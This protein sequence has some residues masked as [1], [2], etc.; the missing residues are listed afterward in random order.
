VKALFTVIGGLALGTIVSAA[1]LVPAFANAKYFPVSQ[2]DIPIDNG[3]N[4][5]LLVFGW[6][7]LTGHSGKSRFVQFVSLA[8]VDTVLF[9]AFCSLVALAKGPRRR[10]SQTL[11]WLAVC[12]IPLFLMSGES[13]WIWKAVPALASAVQFPW[14]FDVV[15]C[16]AALPLAAFVLTDVMQMPVRSRVGFLAIIVLFA[17]TWFGGYA[18]AVRRLTLERDDVGGRFTVHDG[19]FAAWT[20]RGTDLVSAIEAS[21]GPHAR[22]LTGQG[23]ATVLLWKARRIEV[24]TDCAACGP[25][26]VNQFYYPKWEA[27]LVPDGKPLP[28]APALPQGLLEVQVPPGRQHVLLDMP[29]GLDEQIGNWLSALGMMACGILGALGF[30]RNRSGPRPESRA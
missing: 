3:P 30:V 16:I 20:P 25:L 13:Q 24:Q 12:P 26:M 27:R 1:Y 5:D 17:A 2:L 10:R 11:L 6:N 4:G 23:T 15:L 19:W 7:L 21:A 14:R 18:G 9:L 29:Q 28:V 8:T 22:F